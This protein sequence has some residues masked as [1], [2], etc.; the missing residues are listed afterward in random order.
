MIRALFGKAKHI[1]TLT[2]I[3]ELL[4]EFQNDITTDLT[5]TD[6]LAFASMADHI[7][8][9]VIRSRFLDPGGA[10]GQAISDEALYSPNQSDEFFQQ[11]RD[12]LQNILTVSV[13]QK[14]N[15]SIPI[16][17]VNG[18]SDA[19]FAAA[20]ADRLNEMGF[21]VVKI[22]AAAETVDRTR[23]RDHNLSKKGSAVPLLT[24]TFNLQSNQ[25][26]N[27]PR[28]DGPHVAV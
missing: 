10:N 5:L 12:Y 18:T 8:D 7:D 14:A 11:R 26:V 9:T 23:V 25:V 20:A 13:N 15:E 1:G 4:A 21:R 2:K 17:V 24:R 28:A 22:S 16:E 3:P 6:L 27:E 19:G